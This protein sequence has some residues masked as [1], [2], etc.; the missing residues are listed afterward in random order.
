MGIMT[1]SALISAYDKNKEPERALELFEAMKR[2]IVP[3]VIA[4]SALIMACEWGMQPEKALE[5]FGSMSRASP[6]CQQCRVSERTLFH[7]AS[8]GGS[9]CFT[10]WRAYYGKLPSASTSVLGCNRQGSSAKLLRNRQ[11]QQIDAM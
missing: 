4:H 10:C 1:H 8:D 11:W 5:H 7:D 2:G 9:Y 3:G 6:A